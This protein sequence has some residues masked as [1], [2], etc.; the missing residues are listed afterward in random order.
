M[1]LV[2]GNGMGVVIEKRR[3][4]EFVPVKNTAVQYGKGCWPIGRVVGK[5]ITLVETKYNYFELA[6]AV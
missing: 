1:H 4:A 5:N 6:V 2:D 3:F